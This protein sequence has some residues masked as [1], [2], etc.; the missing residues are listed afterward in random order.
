MSWLLFLDESGHDH[1]NMPYEVRG[2]IAIHA[3]EL[4]PFVQSMQRLEFDSFGC[5]L[6]QYR[7]ELKGSTLLDR[8]RFKFARQLSLMA[9]ESRRKHSRGFLTKGLEGKVPTRNEFTAY[10]QAYLEMARGIFQLLAQHS[11]VLFAVV[12]PPIPQPKGFLF[13]DFLRKDQVFLLERFF[14][15]L[16]EKREHGLLVVDEVEKV[17]D[18][19]FVRR[20]EAYFTNTGTGRYRSQW[21]VPSP[22]FVAS[23]MIYAMQAADICIYCVNWGFRIPS[24]G[25][26]A[27]TRS[28]I[29]D[30]FGPWLNR[31]QY[32]GQG[33]RDGAVFESYGVCYVPNPYGP[34][35]A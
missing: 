14:Y 8:K 9:P 27:S 1:K 12:I 5:Q 2:G 34:G 13:E 6:H 20:L 29:A 23:D 11:A 7:K 17:A 32:R 15:F 33:Y 30:E 4:W 35:R 18:R 10:G 21:I 26:N 25:M 31:L 19:A 16:E 22:F 28:E 24:R 3:G